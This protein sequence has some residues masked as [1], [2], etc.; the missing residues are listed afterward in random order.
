MSSNISAGA[1]VVMNHPA[2]YATVSDGAG[3]FVGWIPNGIRGVVYLLARSADRAVVHFEGKLNATVDL[4]HL[5]L[6]AAPAAPP[7][8]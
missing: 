1:T 3:R 4:V 8:A 5:R 7:V 6:D 2:G